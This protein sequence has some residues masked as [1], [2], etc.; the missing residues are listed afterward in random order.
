MIQPLIEVVKKE[1]AIS[2]CTVIPYGPVW[3]ISFPQGLLMLKKMQCIPAKIDWLADVITRLNKAGFKG[4]SPLILTKN[5]KPFIFFNNQLYIVTLWYQGKNPNFSGVSDLKK[6]AATYGYLH[7]TSKLVIKKTT[8]PGDFFKEFQNKYQFLKSLTFN[9]SSGCKFNRIDRTILKWGDY[10]LAQAEISLA[11]L[12]SLNISQW[13]KETFEKGFCHK[14]PAPR[15][16]IIQ[17]SNWFLI[18]YEL[19]GIDFFIDELTTL[20]HRA[21]VVNHWELNVVQI[22]TEAY[23][24]HRKITGTETALIPYLLCFPRQFWR[25]CSQRYQEQLKW[26]ETHFQAKLWGLLNLENE[27]N[28]FLRKWFPDLEKPP[29]GGAV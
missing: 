27:R 21:M 26:K 13:S 16:I 14:D 1:Y 10:F 23:Q 25:L 19:S 4:L 12:R 20:I 3:K 8:E 6:T 18:D 7:Q 9:P 28:N 17:G 29:F 11:G 5:K 15:N 24:T 2:N 22:I